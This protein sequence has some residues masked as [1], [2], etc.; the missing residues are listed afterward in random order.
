M[1]NPVPHSMKEKRPNFK[2]ILENHKDPKNIPR[3]GKSAFTNKR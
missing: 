1:A 2:L 3:G